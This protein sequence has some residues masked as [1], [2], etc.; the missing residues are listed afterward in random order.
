MVEVGHKERKEVCMY[1]H[2]ALRIPKNGI[3]VEVFGGVE[4]QIELLFP[5]TFPLCEYVCMK[6]IR[7]T[8]QVTQKFK[9]YL[10]MNISKR[11]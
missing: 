8:T 11:R 2:D 1:L 3:C 4:P 10:I 7:I 9:I 5:V 6:N